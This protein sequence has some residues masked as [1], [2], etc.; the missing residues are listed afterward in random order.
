M[1][2]WFMSHVYHIQVKLSDTPRIQQA[3]INKK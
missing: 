3:F 2:D 1:H